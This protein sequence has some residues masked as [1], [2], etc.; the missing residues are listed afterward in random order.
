MRIHR[1]DGAVDFRHLPQA[2][3]SPAVPIGLDI[4][5]IADLDDF[6]RPFGHRSHER[7]VQFLARPVQFT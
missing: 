7:V 5:H 6:L 2:V 1:D 4:D 3:T